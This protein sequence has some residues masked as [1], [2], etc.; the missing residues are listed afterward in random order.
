MIPV[1]V[2]ASRMDSLAALAAGQL[3]TAWDRLGGYDVAD[4]LEWHALASPIVGGAAQAAVSGTHAYA[5]ANFTVTGEVPDLLVADRI[6]RVF[7]P[8]DA[9]AALLAK[10]VMFPEALRAAR[11]TAEAV[12]RD[13][14]DSTTRQAMSSLLPEHRQ[15]QRR[16]NP[17]ACDWCMSLA[18]VVWDSG[19]EAEFGHDNCGC[20]AVPVEA[21]DDHNRRIIADRSFDP[22]EYR[23][24]DQLRSLRRSETTARRRQAQARTDLQTEANP[25]RRERLSIR[26]QEWETRAEHAAERI[27]LL[28]TGTHRL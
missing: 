13:A 11:S 21:M 24:R 22:V 5:E 25:A 28:T 14:V 27:R 16:L 9:L 1:G 7:D 2:W 10:G 8:F 23:H 3:A 12:G 19:H 15:W 26:E 4:S 17:G 6:A 18:G 20:R